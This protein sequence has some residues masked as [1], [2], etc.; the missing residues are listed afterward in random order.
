M[1]LLAVSENLTSAA[2]YLHYLLVCPLLGQSDLCHDFEVK[3]TR[4]TCTRQMVLHNADLSQQV[5][6]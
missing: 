5:W 3:T 4:P 1:H 2:S 6:H